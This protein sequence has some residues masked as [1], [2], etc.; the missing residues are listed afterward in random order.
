[1]YIYTIYW[2]LKLNVFILVRFDVLTVAIM[3]LTVFWDIAQCSLVEVDRHFRGAY[4]LNHP[5]DYTALY[6][7]RLSS[8][9]VVIFQLML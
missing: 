5:R 3:K 4:C 9:G 7:R 1:M 8:L 2:I 6:P